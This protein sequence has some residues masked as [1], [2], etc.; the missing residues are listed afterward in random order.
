MLQVHV[1]PKACLGVEP[2]YARLLGIEFPRMEIKHGGLAIDLVDSPD[3][4]ARDGVWHQA[5]ISAAARRQISPQDS[6]CGNRDFE[7]PGP[8]SVGKARRIR[9]TVVVMAHWVDAGAVP[10]IRLGN[11]VECPLIVAAD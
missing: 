10:I 9:D 2:G 1:V 11:A 6:R 7:Q 4:P 3:E 8:R 5:K